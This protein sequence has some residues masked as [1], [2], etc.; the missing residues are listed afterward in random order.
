MK[1]QE[2]NKARYRNHLNKVIVGCIAALVVGSLGIAQGLIAVLPNEQ[3][4]HFHWNVAGVVISCL[5]IGSVLKKYKHHDFMTEVTYVWE[6]KKQ[7]NYI[8]RKM[9]RLKAAVEE[10]DVIAMQIIN[11]SYSGSRQLWLLDD[12]TI[13]MEELSIWQAELDAKAREVNVVLDT[14]KYSQKL[15]ENY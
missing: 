4:S 7:L 2:I 1:L 14:E 8:T 6:L 9:R 13:T 11:Y 5:V 12:N 3:G 10:G 15:L